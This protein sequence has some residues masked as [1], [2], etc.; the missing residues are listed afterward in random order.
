MKELK[1]II[2]V[3]VTPFAEDGSIVYSDADRHIDWMIDSGVHSIM[4]VGATGEFAALTTS[5]RKEFS[6]FVMKKV[7]GRV[8]V[9]IGA[10]SQRIGET[11]E[12]AEHASSIGADAVMCLPSPGLHL[13][14]DEIYGFYKHLSEHVTLPVIIYN[15]PGS[16]G[17]D[18]A[19][20]T[21]AR[22]VDLPHMAYIKESTGDLKRLTRVVDELGDKIVPLCGC[23]NLA[24]ESF[25]MGAQGW[26]CV[27]ANIAPAMSA[28]IYEYTKAGE[29]DK[30]R[31][32]YRQV[33]PMLRLFEESGQLWQ[34]AKY[35]LKVRGMG[36]GVCRL[37]RQ[38]ISADVRAAV[39]ALL[40]TTELK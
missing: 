36:T 25:L 33:L 15:N 30:A 24:M 34:V 11:L 40:A 8:P 22:I 21:L 4:S 39:D 28:Q 38:P 16:S 27:L 1:G 5:E 18:I 31:A 32:V 35:V 19:P 6:E 13:R 37:P 23:E 7:A 10:V 9:C 20:E 12:I 3:M 2:A 14:Q 29:L 17:V 26:V